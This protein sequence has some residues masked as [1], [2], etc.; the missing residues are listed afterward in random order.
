MHS[1][2]K[3]GLFFGSFNPIHMGHMIIANIM[4]E[5]TDLYKVWFV[6]SPQNPF[7][8]SKGLLHEFDR[9]DMVRAAIHDNYKL[10]VSDVEFHLPKPSFTI[11]TLVNLHEKYPEKE[12]K[13]IIGED[14]LINFAK[15]KNHGQILEQY[16]LYV[17]PRP[18]AQPSELKTHPNVKFV[19]AP[20]LD[21][22]ATFIRNCI[23]KKQSVRYL[24]PDAVEEMIR[25]KGYF[26]D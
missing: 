12:F 16:G 10:D 1:A 17:Y 4:A 21:I 19:D 18:N 23:R 15:W 25:T 20:M 22:S 2:Q 14:N 13:V 26:L 6:V 7:K 11:H 3:I 9:Y 8:P 5:T 24:V